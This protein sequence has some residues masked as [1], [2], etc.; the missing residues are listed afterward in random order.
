MISA[1][2]EREIDSWPLGQ[3]FSLAPRMQAITLDVIMAGIFGIEGRPAAGTPEARLRQTV[4][5]VVAASTMPTAALGELIQ[6][7]REEA[8]GP[9]RL[10]VALLDRATYGVI[11]ER[12]RATDLEK[13]RDIL[14]LLLQART[15][16]GEALR[17]KELRDE[18]LTLVLAGH[19][20]TANSLAL[21]L[22]APGSHARGPRGAARRGPLRRGRRGANRGDDRRGDALATG[23]P[24]YRPPCDG[25]LAPRRV[26]RAG[27][28]PSADQHPPGPPP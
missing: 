1:A 7:G 8:V 2:N 6:I 25:A 21:G 16:D 20:T 9:L 10:V 18:L 19:E 11:A 27:G 3:P 23:D 13:R 15:E 22:G 5:R 14:S 26:R 12:R 4:K 24:D 17:D 28:D